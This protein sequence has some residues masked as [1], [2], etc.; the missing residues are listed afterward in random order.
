MKVRVLF[1]ASIRERAGRRE[2]TVSLPE[3]T[4]LDQLVRMIGNE[5]APMTE[6]ERMMLSING[7]YASGEEVLRD[8]DEV[9]LLPPVSGG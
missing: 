8:G 5:I 3:G 6:G 4:V 7:K 1:F 9:A 2:V